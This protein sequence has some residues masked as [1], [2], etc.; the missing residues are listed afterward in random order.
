MFE[1]V[2]VFSEVVVKLLCFFGVGEVAVVVVMLVRCFKCVVVFSEV[3][4]K[5][6]CF[7][8]VGEVAV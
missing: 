6:L 5:L 3:V 4:V 7:F 2:V 1:C 8:G